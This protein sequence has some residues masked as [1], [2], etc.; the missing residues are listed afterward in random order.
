MRS[1]T[2]GLTDPGVF[3]LK[4]NSLRLFGHMGRLP[5]VHYGHHPNIAMQTFLSAD[6]TEAV[7]HG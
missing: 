2:D 1:K 5:D 6:G 3:G 7:K 4:R